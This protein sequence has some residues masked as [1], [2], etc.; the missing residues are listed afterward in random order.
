MKN[1][2]SALHSSHQVRTKK[3]ERNGI[4]FGWQDIEDLKAREDARVDT[5]Q[6]RFVRG[7]LDSYI[8]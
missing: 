8:V 2:I 7:L 4:Q 3:F 5:G 6:I 1:M